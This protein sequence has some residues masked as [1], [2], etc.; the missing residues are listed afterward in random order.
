MCSA[1]CFKQHLASRVG[2]V[3]GCRNVL[4]GIVDYFQLEIDKGQD[5]RKATGALLLWCTQRSF[6]WTLLIALRLVSQCCSSSGCEHNWST[7]ALV[8]IKVRNQMSH[9]KLHK[10]VYVNYNLGLCLKDALWFTSVQ[11]RKIQF[12]S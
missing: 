1:T 4:P 6:R 11:G 5:K 9:K 10:L 7:F 8:H 2:N 3:Q 12:I